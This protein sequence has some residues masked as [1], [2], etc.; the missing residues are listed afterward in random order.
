MMNSWRENEPQV[1]VPPHFRH[2]PGSGAFFLPSFFL[3]AIVHW[4]AGKK[5]QE[6]KWHSG[7]STF[8]SLP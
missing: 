7:W 3:P 6:K 8:E 1:A 4:L 2:A 5:G